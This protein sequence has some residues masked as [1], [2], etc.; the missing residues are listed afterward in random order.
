MKEGSLMNKKPKIGVGIFEQINNSN[1][2]SYIP[3]N[4]SDIENLLK[5]LKNERPGMFSEDKKYPRRK[6]LDKK[7]SNT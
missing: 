1:K 7:S 3:F 2:H 5:E 6:F 4:L